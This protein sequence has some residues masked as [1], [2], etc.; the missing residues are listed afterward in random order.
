MLTPRYRKADQ[1]DVGSSDDGPS[2][3]ASRLVASFLILGCGVF[4]VLF[5]ITRS[6]RAFDEHLLASFIL[7][8]LVAGA[9]FS[10]SA[11]SI[12]SYQRSQTRLRRRLS[13]PEPV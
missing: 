2:S 9:L 8:G 12:I 7:A 4:G 3:I 10:L 5:L 11:F 13:E 1:T 6:M